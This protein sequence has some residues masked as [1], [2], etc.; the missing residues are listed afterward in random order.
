[1]CLLVSIYKY[2]CY[3]QPQMIM[4][5]P[6]RNQIN[7]FTLKVPFAMTVTGNHIQTL[8]W[9][10]LCHFPEQQSRHKQTHIDNCTMAYY[11]R[12]FLRKTTE[13]RQKLAISTTK[14]Y[15][16]AHNAVNWFLYYSNG[17]VT[18][19]PSVIQSTIKSVNNN[20]FFIGIVIRTR[21]VHNIC[22][23]TPVMQQWQQIYRNMFLN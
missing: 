22:R 20:Q 17:L 11:I 1:M 19:Y 15:W 13:I 23:L 6:S 10:V 16:Y 3:K 8:R 21:Q 18:N 5:H 7:Q 14:H 12:F 2:G 4:P 9:T